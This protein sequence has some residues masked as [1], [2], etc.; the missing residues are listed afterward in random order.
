MKIGWESTKSPPP[1]DCT[2]LQKKIRTATEYTKG[3][4][5]ANIS[6]VVN[7]K[8]VIVVKR[9]QLFCARFIACRLFF[10]A[11]FIWALAFRAYCQVKPLYTLEIVYSNRVKANAKRNFFSV[12]FSEN[13]KPPN[14]KNGC[15]D[16]LRKTCMLN[17]IQK[18]KGSIF[19]LKIPSR[20]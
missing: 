13:N 2:I 15:G 19:V 6:K 14:I 4:L 17:T 10:S 5:I 18:Y 1:V 3:N 11:P 7:K 12:I 16:L 8:L 20:R 9:Y